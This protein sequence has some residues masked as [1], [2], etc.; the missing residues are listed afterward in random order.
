[1][2]YVKTISTVRKVGKHVQCT[3]MDIIHLCNCGQ[4]A[5]IR[6]C[7]Y[8]SKPPRIGTSGHPMVDSAFRD[9]LNSNK[10]T[11]MPKNLSELSHSAWQSSPP[12]S[13]SLGLFLCSSNSSTSSS[14]TFSSLIRLLMAPV[15]LGLILT[16][17]LN[18]SCS[19]AVYLDL[20]INQ[21][22]VYLDLEDASSSLASRQA[23]HPT[24]SRRV[25]TGLS[26]LI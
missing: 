16:R 24:P 10:P 8:R 3:L 20:D 7:R 4:E 9:G 22:C 17:I 14:F 12:G 18:P 11:I 26:M 5:L 6:D 1:M 2:H 23:L 21:C 19:A 25:S 13:P 15:R